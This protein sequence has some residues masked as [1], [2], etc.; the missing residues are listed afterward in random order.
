MPD[1]TTPAPPPAAVTP[2]P[3]PTP[4]Q[5]L[6]QAL[7]EETAIMEA[8]AKQTKTRHTAEVAHTAWLKSQ[9]PHK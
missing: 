9:A 2:P 4:A 3:P 8:L 5:V 1:T 6:H 7:V